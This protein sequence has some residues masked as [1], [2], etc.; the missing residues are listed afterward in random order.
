MRVDRR[1]FILGMPVAAAAAWLA[2]H[3]TEL[4]A[5]AEHVALQSPS[6]PYEFF[7]PEQVTEFDAISAQI[8]PTDDT[9]G[10]RE[11]NVV[12]FVD[13]YV[14]TVATDAQSQLRTAF[15][16]IADAVESRHAGVRLFASLGA[17]DQ[18]ALLT[19]FEQSNRGTF[20]RFRDFTFLGM[21]SDPVH[22]GNAGKVGWRL[23]GFEDRHAWRPPFGYYDRA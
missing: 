9:P 1:D 8:V 2:A 6:Q 19:S 11:A 5:V 23:L 21:F 16:E 3:Q 20:N 13:R 12:R 7:T 10:A 4:R 18:I 14:A 15:R 17:A 22:G